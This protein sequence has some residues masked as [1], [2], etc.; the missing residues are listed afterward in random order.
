ME[1]KTLTVLDLEIM[2]LKVTRNMK[3]Q[4]EITCK[5]SLKILPRAFGLFTTNL[6]D[7]QGEVTVITSLNGGNVKTYTLQNDLESASVY[8]WGIIDTDEFGCIQFNGKQVGT[9]TD[10]FALDRFTVASR[11]QVDDPAEEIKIC[12]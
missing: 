6:G 1:G 9:S 11:D 8:F 2:L 10:Q 12:I 5:L 7:F 3:L 4:L